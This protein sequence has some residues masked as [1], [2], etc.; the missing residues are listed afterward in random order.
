MEEVYNTSWT[1]KIT[2]V[3][4][5]PFAHFIFSCP[6]FIY[7]TCNAVNSLLHLWLRGHIWQWY[8]NHSGIFLVYFLLRIFDTRWILFLI[9]K[10]GALWFYSQVI[11]LMIGF[12][13][14]IWQIL[15]TLLLSGKQFEINF[16]AIDFQIILVNCCLIVNTVTINSNKNIDLILFIQVL[17]LHSIQVGT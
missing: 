14:F 10:I 17:N 11:N 15:I 7:S 3:W 13:N 8:W 12:R 4:R 16:G 6:L 9:S 5:P 2:Y 1:E